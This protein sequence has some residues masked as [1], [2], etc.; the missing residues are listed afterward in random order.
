MTSG[1]AALPSPY[2]HLIF[3]KYSVFSPHDPDL[4]G[5][6]SPHDFNCAVSSPNAILGSRTSSDILT[7]STLSSQAPEGAHFSIADPASMIANGLQPYFSLLSFNIK[8]MDF[9]PPWTTIK[10]IGYSTT[11][12]NS[13]P[14]TW[15]VNFPAGYHLP[16]YVKMQEYSGDDWDQLHGVEIVADFGE[17]YLDWEF[18]LDDLEVQFFKA[19]RTKGF[20]GQRVDDQV[21]LHEI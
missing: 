5:I 14:I 16:L 11:R 12:N 17:Q 10:V 21:V 1:L 9:P 18:C 13:H 3:S 19:N 2:H 6:I 4:D 15:D 20:E 7:N 8:P